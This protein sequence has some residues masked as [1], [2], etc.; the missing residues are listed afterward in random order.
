MANSAQAKKRARQNEKRELH[1]ASQRSAVRTAVK[2]ILK[3]LQANDSSAA[4]SA[5][6][7]AVQ[8]LDKAAGRRIIHPNKAARLKSRLSQKIKNLSSSQ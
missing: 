8:I 5:Y 4:Q 6:Q 2:K 3:S 1:N 7:H